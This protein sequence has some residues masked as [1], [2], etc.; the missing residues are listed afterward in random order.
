MKSCPVPSSTRDQVW[1][2]VGCGLGIG[3]YKL[4]QSLA[5]REARKPNL[6][7]PTEIVKEE[8]LTV[9][10]YEGLASTQTKALSLAEIVA[11]RPF[12]NAPQENKFEEWIVVTAGELDVVC[13]DDSS[14]TI[15]CPAGHVLYIPPGRYS[16]NYTMPQTRYFALC[17]PSFAPDTVRFNVDV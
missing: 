7:S 17:A 3:L 8:N 1:L 14:N 11:K 15:K 13:H 16:L 10:E 2:L 9:L 6:V 5:T 12:K 4:Y